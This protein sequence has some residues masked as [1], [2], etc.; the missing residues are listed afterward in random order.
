MSRLHFRIHA[1]QIDL[2][3][4]LKTGKFEVDDEDGNGSDNAIPEDDDDDFMD[5]LEEPSGPFALRGDVKPEIFKKHITEDE[6]IEILGSGH[7]DK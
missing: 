2:K 3:E 5:A 6:A 1:A 7:V 4:R